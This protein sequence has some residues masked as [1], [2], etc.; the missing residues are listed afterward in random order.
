MSSSDRKTILITG[1]TD[2]LG[3]LVAKQVA[4]EQMKLLIHGRDR[5]KGNRVREELI[6]VSGNKDISYYNSDFASFDEVK[7]LAD[8]IL[9]DHESI[10]ILVNNVGIGSGKGENK[11]IEYSID[12]N[13]L[14][15]QVNYLSHVLLTE[16][17]LGIINKKN[18]VI[19][20]VASI[21]QEAIDFSNIMLEKGYD[22]Y[23]AYKRSKSAMIM[24]SYDLA[25]RLKNTGIRVN[26]LHPASLMNT[27]MVLQD[28]GYTLSTVED[29]AKAVVNLLSPPA[30]G[31]YFD[32]MH[33]AKSIPQTYIRKE[34]EMLHKITWKILDRYLEH[35][36]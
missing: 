32:G 31:Q 12:G 13:E 4:Q 21:G 28:W 30:T 26:S 8:K 2:G 10:D 24:Y 29:G 7:T 5:E 22:G 34:R 18:G 33:T 16:K 11:G 25:D 17:L 35:N 36:D 1:A 9:S 20:N 14:R 3:K 15:L 19:I 6:Q 27:N 23:F